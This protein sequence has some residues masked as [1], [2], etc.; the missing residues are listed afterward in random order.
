[1]R[2]NAWKQAIKGEN[3]DV[4]TSLWSRRLNSSRELHNYTE[5]EKHANSSRQKKPT[6]FPYHFAV[7]RFD[8]KMGAIKAEEPRTSGVR[9]LNVSSAHVCAR[10]TRADTPH[11]CILPLRVSVLKHYGSACVLSLVLVISRVQFI[12]FYGFK[13]IFY[14]IAYKALTFNRGGIKGWIVT[15]EKC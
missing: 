4:V 10:K 15:L 8:L 11:K 3:R 7:R 14:A 1:M 12:R 2:G 13:H 6:K 5:F 9:Y